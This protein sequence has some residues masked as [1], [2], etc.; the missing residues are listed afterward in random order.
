MLRTCLVFL[1]ALNS[2]YLAMADQGSDG[3]VTRERI[4]QLVRQMRS[5][6]F[7]EAKQAEE[8]LVRLGPDYLAVIR[9][10]APDSRLVQMHD[11]LQKAL[12]DKKLDLWQRRRMAFE[13]IDYFEEHKGVEYIVMALR[14]DTLH[15]RSYALNAL[16]HIATRDEKAKK[17]TVEALVYAMKNPPLDWQD[18]LRSG[19]ERGTGAVLHELRLISLAGHLM[20][21]KFDLMTV[22]VKDVIA[23]CEAWLKSRKD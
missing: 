19:D 23:Q 22:K 9:H 21:V 4:E 8:T 7:K 16:G 1:L 6:N 18:E 10:L 12:T 2:A 17:V 14:A 11:K 3:K 5:D 13:A 15:I 20:G